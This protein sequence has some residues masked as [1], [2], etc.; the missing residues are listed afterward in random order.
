MEW[1]KVSKELPST[2]TEVLIWNGIY[3]KIGTYEWWD[4]HYQWL[5][6]EWMEIKGV[7]HWMPLPKTPEI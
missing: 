5:S 7:T 2:E 1:K 4:P 3:L 6:S